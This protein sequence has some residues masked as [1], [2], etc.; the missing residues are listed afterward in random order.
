MLLFKY[1]CLG[2]SYGTYIRVNVPQEDKPRYQTRKNEI[3][4]NVLGVCS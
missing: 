1:N 4:T 2:A 3:A